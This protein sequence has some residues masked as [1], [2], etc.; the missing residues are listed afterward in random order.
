M[1]QRDIQ[2]YFLQEDFKKQDIF[3]LTVY[4]ITLTNNSSGK[5]AGGYYNKYLKYKSKYFELKKHI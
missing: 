3:Y 1:S 4:Y 2:V 5:F